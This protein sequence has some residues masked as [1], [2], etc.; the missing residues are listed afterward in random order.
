MPLGLEN[1]LHLLMVLVVVLLVFGAKRMPEMGRNLGK[2]MR[3]FK[4][5]ISGHEPAELPGGSGSSG[6]EA[7]SS[8]TKLA[9]SVVKTEGDS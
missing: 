7:A 8:G 3:E 6:P 9:E 1:P 2:G 4:D 5:S